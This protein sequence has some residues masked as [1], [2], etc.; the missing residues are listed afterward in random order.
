[1]PKNGIG[2]MVGDLYLPENRKEGEKL[3][4]ILLCAGAGGTKGGARAGVWG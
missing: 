3:P 1:M 2:T 4:A